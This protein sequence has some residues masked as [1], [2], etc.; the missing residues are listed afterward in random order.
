LDDNCAYHNHKEQFVVEEILEN[1]VLISLQFTG[2]DFVEY[3]QQDEYV[4]EDRVVFASFVI[5]V[6]HVN[7]GWNSEKFWA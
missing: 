5:P 7:R 4:E 3:L 2:V 6:F 1:V